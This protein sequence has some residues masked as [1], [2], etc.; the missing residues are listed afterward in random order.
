[1][2]MDKEQKRREIQRQIQSLNKQIQVLV[3]EWGRLDLGLPLV[4]HK[5]DPD[6]IPEFLRRKD[7]QRVTTRP[8]KTSVVRLDVL[9]SRLRGKRELQE[10]GRGQD[11]GRTGEA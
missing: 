8:V 3:R 2:A 1:M 10:R 7:E 5:H 11:P 4:D 6:Y 9:R